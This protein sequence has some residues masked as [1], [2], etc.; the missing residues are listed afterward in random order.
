MGPLMYTC[1]SLS[2]DEL[3]LRGLQVTD[4]TYYGVVPPPFLTSKELSSWEDFLD[5]ENEKYVVPYLLSGQGPASSP[6]GPAIVFLEFWSL[7]IPQGINSICL[8][9]GRG[10]STTWLSSI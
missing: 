1:A 3:H 7:D 6:D 2:Q 10:A 5:F 4:I 8:P 9:W